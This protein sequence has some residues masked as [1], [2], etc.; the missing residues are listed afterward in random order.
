M[1]GSNAG[2]V[3]REK[4]VCDTGLSEIF[5][6]LLV[7]EYVR[8]GGGKSVQSVQGRRDFVVLHNKDKETNMFA[9]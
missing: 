5:Y 7:H 3:S 2:V 6:L 4:V 8:R 9:G 1:K